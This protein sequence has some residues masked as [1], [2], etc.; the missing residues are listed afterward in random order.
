MP[1]NN[2]TR[3]KLSKEPEVQKGTQLEGPQRSSPSMPPFPEEK[4]EGPA[5]K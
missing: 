5:G 2:A 1:E 3:E 4:M